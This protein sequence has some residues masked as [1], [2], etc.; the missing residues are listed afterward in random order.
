MPN[1]LNA[2]QVWLWRGYPI[3]YQSCGQTGPAVV[4]VHGFGACWGHWRK[5]LPVLGEHFRTF[6]LYLIGFGASA[7]PLPQKE[8]EYTFATW[9][10][11]LGDFCR[12][13]VGEP[14]FL[15]GNSIGC[16]V[17]MQC[18]VDFPSQVRGLVALNCSLRLLH[19]RKR[20]GLPWYQQLGTPI[21]QWFLGNRTLGG[22][23][24]R[25]LAQP[26]TIRKILVQAYGDPTAVTDELVNLLLTPAHDPGAVDVFL[27]FTRYSQGPLPEDLL[28]QITCPTLLVWGE[29]DPWEPVALGQALGDYACVEEFRVL[30]GVGHCPQDEAPARVNALLIEW[31]EQKAQLGIT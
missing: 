24:F 26:E 17:V 8:I 3:T 14:C 7:K 23:F 19:E 10:Q 4:L 20:S 15:V 27:A 6:A 22:F 21:L 13:I 16:V 12:E 11:L 2:P 25:Q 30:P 18:A 31:L 1:F 9:S 29:A 5:N 28:P